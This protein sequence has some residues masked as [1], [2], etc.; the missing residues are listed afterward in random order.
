MKFVKILRTHFYRTPLVAAS[1]KFLINSVKNKLQES[2]H[3]VYQLIQKTPSPTKIEFLRYIGV[4]SSFQKIGQIPLGTKQK[5]S[6]NLSR[7][8][9]QIFE[10][11]IVM[12]HVTK[13]C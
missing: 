1:V 7:L 5:N 3:R 12:F 13:S 4:Y 11:S 6:K 10:K 9:E 2:H 8:F